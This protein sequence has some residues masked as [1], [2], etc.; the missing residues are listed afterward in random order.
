M[1]AEWVEILDQVKSGQITA[2]EGADRLKRL[3]EQTAAAERVEA[4][5]AEL[6]PDGAGSHPAPQ[7]G[8]TVL[9]D[10]L[11]RWQRWWL[12]PFWAGLGVFMFG[13]ALMAWSFTNERFF[14]FACAWLPLLLG[15]TVLAVSAWSR[16]ARWLHVRI[17]D[18]GKDGGKPTRIA[19]SMPVPIHLTGWALRVFGPMFPKFKDKNLDT[20]GPIL[21][22][23]GDSHEPLTVEVDDKDGEKVQVYIV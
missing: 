20:I 5:G 15:L 21:E 1:K 6:P 9:D 22:S 4:A 16:T 10:T 19:I 11:T 13:S 12:Y 8:S 2:E 17:N 23:L 18:P 7:A 14:W 3:E